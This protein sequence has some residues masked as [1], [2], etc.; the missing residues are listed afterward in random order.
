M[1][2]VAGEVLV[3]DVM[4][5]GVC[6]FVVGVK[7]FGAGAGE[8]AASTA[9]FSFSILVRIFFSEL[10]SRSCFSHLENDLADRSFGLSTGLFM[11]KCADATRRPVLVGAKSN[12]F[13]TPRPECNDERGPLIGI[14]SGPVHS[15]RFPPDEGSSS[16]FVSTSDFCGVTVG[17]GSCHA[18][19]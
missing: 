10:A 1:G 11:S 3:S 9:A 17:L 18:K 8:R 16:C 12:G 4:G 14:G 15:R 7:G 2:A 13:W 19:S 6:M 5:G